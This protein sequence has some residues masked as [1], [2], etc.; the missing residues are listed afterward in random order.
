[1]NWKLQNSFSNDVIDISSRFEMKTAQ[2]LTRQLVT[3][4]KGNMDEILMIKKNKQKH[5][6]ISYVRL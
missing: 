5:K 4:T 2:N 1:M 3:K 6:S